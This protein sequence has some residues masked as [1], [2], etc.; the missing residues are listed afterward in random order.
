MGIVHEERAGF[1]IVNWMCEDSFRSSLVHWI[2]GLI[3]VV[4]KPLYNTFV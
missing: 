1:V 2:L 3:Y 4:R